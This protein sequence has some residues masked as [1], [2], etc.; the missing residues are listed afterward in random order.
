MSLVNCL[1]LELLFVGFILLSV[2][3][4]NSI[5]LGGIESRV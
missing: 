1:Y 3:F 4:T 5:F 2:R